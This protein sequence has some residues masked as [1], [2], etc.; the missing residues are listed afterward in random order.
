[1]KILEQRSS[2]KEEDIENAVNPEYPYIVVKEKSVSYLGVE[3]PKADGG[4][5]VPKESEFKEE[6]FYLE[7]HHET[8]REI[9]TSLL[10]NKPLLLEG[11]TGVYNKTTTVAKMCKDLNANYCKVNFDRETAREDV[12][13]GQTLKVDENGKEKLEWYDGDLMYA[14]R[15][16]GVAF[17]DEY[18]RQSKM[19]G[20]INPIIDAI[21]N[22][23]KEITN[24]YNENERVVVHPNFR[25]VAAQN[26][27]GFEE[28]HEYTDRNQLPAETFGRWIYKKLPIEYTEDQENKLFAGMIGEGVQLDIPESEFRHVGEGLPVKELAEVPGMVHWRR[29]IITILRTLEAKSSGSKREMAKNQRQN[30]YFNPRLKKTIID[31]IA[32]FYSGDINETIKNA[33]E[34]CIVGMYSSDLD[35]QKVRLLVDQASWV[36][37][38]VESKR[39][40]LEARDI[41]AEK[42]QELINEIKGLKS[43]IEDSGKLPKGFE[44]SKPDMEKNPIIQAKTE[45][46]EAIEFNFEQIKTYWINFYQENN[47]PEI[48]EVVEKMKINLTKEQQDRIKELSEKK[49]FNKMIIFAGNEIM[50]NNS[51]RIKQQTEKEMEGLTPEQQYQEKDESGKLIGA[52][53]SDSVKSAFPE[54]IKNNNRPNKPYIFRWY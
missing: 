51:E 2:E 33:F 36:A 35:K 19:A 42:K 45:K 46:G 21:L 3:V 43:E 14:I 6:Y 52:Y 32:R 50:K 29:E 18:N 28:G 47:L 48:A 5:L 15:N 34:T 1:M 49:G 24:P 41:E 4:R 13:G 39:R 53:L 16:G 31:Y 27:P 22:G 17:L 25:L 11:G 40:G 30:L 44:M 23:R 37:P 20:I 54:K 38:K 9:A 10:L 7:G 8:M 26:P 12:I